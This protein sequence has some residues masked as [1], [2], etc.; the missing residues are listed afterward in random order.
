MLFQC[1]KV[2]FYRGFYL[3][4]ALSFSETA[5]KRGDMV[6]VDVLIP[7][8]LDHTYS[9][10]IPE[11][12]ELVPGD[13]V[14]VPF[15][16]REASGVVWCVRSEPTTQQ[17]LKK[18]SKKL[19]LP[20]IPEKLRQFIDWTSWYTLA[21]KGLVLA[22]AL[23]VPD[24]GREE[25]VR[26]GVRFTGLFPERLTPARQRVL[27]I[28]QSGLTFL[29]KDLAVETAVSVAVIDGLIDAGTLEPLP[30]LQK[31]T[32]EQPDSTYCRPDLSL[33]Q[34]SAADVLC[35]CIIQRDTRPVLVHGV[36]GS[37]KTEVY[38]EAVAQAL[39]L[40][41]QA[42]VL[43]PEIALTSQFLERFA[44]RFGTQPAVWHSGIT[45]RKRERLYDA[46]A[47]GEMRVVVG[48]RSALFL[49]YQDLG[50][51]VVDEEH[52]PGYKQEDGV[53][54]HARDMAVVRA[55][56]ENAAIVLAS[57][58]PSLETQINVD[59]GKYQHV[60]LTERFGGRTLPDIRAIN[61]KKE[62][63]EN[64]HWLSPKLIEKTE[65]VLAEGHQ[66]LFYLNR[67]GYAP[68]TLCRS[69]GHRYECPNCS[70][71][72]VEHRYRKAL[73][74][75]L[76][77]HLEPR[78]SICVECGSVDS[79]VSC[80]PGVE[81]IAEEVA[82]QFPN[83]RH[84]ILSSDLSGG[85]KR[86]HQELEAVAKGEY[87]ILIGTQ[88]VAKG[89]NFPHLA[90]VGVIDA[91]VGMTSGDPRASERTFQ[92]LQQVAGRSGR[93]SAKGRAFLQTW[94]PDHPVIRALL[95]G[96]EEQ[97]Y[98]QEKLIREAALMPPFGRLAALIISGRDKNN[99]EAAARL[100]ARAAPFC[101]GVQ[102]LGPVEAP[103]AL[104]RKRYRFRILVKA[105][106]S[107]NLQDYLRNWI[108]HSPK[109]EGGVRLAIDVDPYSFQ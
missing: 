1:P 81:R 19:D 83:H 20:G 79:L 60:C 34:R 25:K 11:G 108:A 82:E 48:A 91:D 16:S 10:Q 42:L 88:L 101:D 65:G 46:L 17:S 50:L 94:Q 54:Y 40:K 77:G 36:T 96:D 6:C 55:R 30:V 9:Y 57:A 93:G 35:R 76:C 102:V 84:I 2:L 78:P 14:S 97:F 63:L 23:K 74:C 31:N 47:S 51:I 13:V 15:G 39:E 38:F 106:R 104:V 89:H 28:V 95:S 24:E 53:C 21:P 64:G 85:T 103:L 105:S 87:D 32:F 33:D 44:R 100:F 4:A 61:L 70:S 86:L 27:D 29:K 90:L 99:T 68:L 67:R 12:L 75:H 3:L 45:G 59:K 37:G 8:A 98:A 43:M 41:R 71:W 22:M 49:P 7:V 56:F 52:E 66:V 69:C 5:L 18:V 58:T 107:V 26:V 72:L 73:V 109:R 62:K 92:L 80:G